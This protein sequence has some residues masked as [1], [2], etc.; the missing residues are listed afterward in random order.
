MSHT[1]THW[2]DGNSS[3]VLSLLTR[4]QILGCFNMQIGVC[5][6]RWIINWESKADYKVDH[7]Y[8]IHGQVPVIDKGKQEEVHQHDGKEDKAGNRQTACDEQY[9]EEDGGDR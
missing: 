1:W 8:V 3:F 7:N 5:Y 6:V 9:H 4:C 2:A